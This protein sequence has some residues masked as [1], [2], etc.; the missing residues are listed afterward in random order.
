MFAANDGG[1]K[2]LSELFSLTGKRAIITGSASG[3]GLASAYRFAEAGANLEL[4]DINKDG[5][6][7]AKDYLSQFKVDVNTHVVDLSKKDQIDA[8]W[9]ELMKRT[10]DILVNNA[11]IYPFKNFLEVDRSFYNK[12]M[13]INIESVFWMCQHMIKSRQDT[14]GVIINVGSIE[15]ILP[16]K[17]ELSH[18][19]IS[20][21]GVIALTRSLAKEYGKTFRVNAIIPGGIV[22]P[23]TKNVA[24]DILKLRLD[25]VITGLEFKSR[26]PSGRFGHPD[27]V[28]RIA[29]V[30]ASDLSTYIN[31]ALVPV[32]GGFLSA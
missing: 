12:V 11:G 4:I 32:D 28:A 14:G 9:A 22:T 23:G 3:I 16:F 29:V 2:P 19:N 17:G 31:G 21:S 26:L 18:Y 30:L 25:L 15:A 7:S 10:P 6:Q 27:E 24:K 13:E 8:L 5:L 20:K 1:M